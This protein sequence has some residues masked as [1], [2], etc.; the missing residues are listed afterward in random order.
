MELSFT[1][2]ASS[3]RFCEN[4]FPRKW[5]A[6]WYTRKIK[7]TKGKNKVH[8][9]ENPHTYT[10]KAFASRILLRSSEKIVN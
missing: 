9:T 6:S 4:K 8:S 2:F 7:N 3:G 1:N 5:I 10:W